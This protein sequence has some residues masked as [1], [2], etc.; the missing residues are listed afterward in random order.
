LGYNPAQFS[1]ALADFRMRI[2]LSI[3]VALSLAFPVIAQQPQCKENHPSPELASTPTTVASVRASESL[4]KLPD[5]TSLEVVR[6]QKVHYP[7]KARKKKIQGQVQLNVDISETG[8]V[9][10][11]EPLSGN[12]ELIP[13]AMNAVK[14]WKYKPYLRNGKAVKVTTRLPLDF[15]LPENIHE[16]ALDTTPLPASDAPSSATTV[17]AAAVMAGRLVHKVTPVYPASA[18][19]NHLQATVVLQAAI[20]EQGRISELKVVS[21]PTEFVEA[22]IGAVQQWRYRPYVLNGEPVAVTT[23][24]QLPYQLRK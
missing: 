14:K 11:V 1:S 4:P 17:V 13:A 23:Q 15:A 21:G 18:R 12:P 10:H 20:N 8:A 22:S 7:R 2:L 3:C 6:M 5:S 16:I 19:A 9:E 24:I